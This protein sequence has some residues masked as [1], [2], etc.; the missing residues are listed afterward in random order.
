M[1][2]WGQP[3]LADGVLSILH[4]E[5]LFGWDE[6]DTGDTVDGDC[7]ADPGLRARLGTEINAQLWLR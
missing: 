5:H 7:P 6:E 1:E 4:P 2:A 3:V